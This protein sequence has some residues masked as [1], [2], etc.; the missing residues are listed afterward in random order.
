VHELGENGAKALTL[1]RESVA[2][3]FEKPGRNSVQP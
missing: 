2:H 1:S 3:G